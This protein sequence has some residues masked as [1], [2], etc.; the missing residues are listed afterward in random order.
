MTTKRLFNGLR[1]PMVT[2]ETSRQRVQRVQS[3]TPKA[4]D[5][6]RDGYLET[7]EGLGSGARPNQKLTHDILYDV[8]VGKFSPNLQH[9]DG[10][11]GFQESHHGPGWNKSSL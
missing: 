4:A 7:E 11:H 10:L 1:L 3:P 5:P 6:R 9:H 8:H 2:T